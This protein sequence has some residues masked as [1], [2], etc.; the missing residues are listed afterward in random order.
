MGNS[1]DLKTTIKNITSE[2]LKG[3]GIFCGQNAGGV[4]AI[5]GTI[6]I[7]LSSLPN[8][9]EFPTSD[10]SNGGVAV[11]M[12]LHTPTIY[13]IRYQGFLWYNAVSI[14]NYAAKT[15]TLWKKPCKLFVRGVGMEGSIGPVA[16][17]I[18]HN[19]MV[20]MPGIK[21][22]APCTP[23]EY[24]Q[25][26]EDFKAGDD[27]VFCSE[28]RI[29]YANEDVENIN[30][31]DGKINVFLI[32]GARI[33]TLELSKN[34]NLNVFPIV[35]LSPLDEKIFEY[36]QLNHVVGNVVV[37]C[38]YTVCGASEHIAYQLM[39]KTN[40]R[41]IA[42][43]LEHKTAGF[44]PHTDNLIPPIEKIIKAIQSLLREQ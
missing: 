3:G 34:D 27:P 43:G 21:V 13:A 10:S 12:A 7:E 31:T 39:V 35:N 4:G 38:G 40:K 8:F 37:D 26:W 1:P 25:A 42:I 29:C 16:G 14:V 9:V 28:H 6:P 11:G 5:C 32:G 44:A 20:S 23:S 15:Q 17:N 33:H 22:V 30:Y 41:S 2:H 36:S 19:L 24:I 18:H